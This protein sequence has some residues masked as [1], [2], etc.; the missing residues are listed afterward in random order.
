MSKSKEVKDFIQELRKAGYTVT[1][2]KRGH[3]KVYDEGRLIHI[4]PVTPSDRR[5]MQNA[6]SDIRARGS[7]PL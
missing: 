4:V 3:H 2:T 7:K 1:R 5:W 6:R